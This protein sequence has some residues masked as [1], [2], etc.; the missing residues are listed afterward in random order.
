MGLSVPIGECRAMSS[1][2]HV[3]AVE[4]IVRSSVLL[5]RSHKLS[6]GLL[7]RIA[8]L[9]HEPCRASHKELVVMSKKGES[10]K[11]NLFRSLA[12]HLS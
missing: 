6:F 2:P 4:G 7:L 9:C 11:L 3:V 8:G 10:T 12:T 1:K 5:H